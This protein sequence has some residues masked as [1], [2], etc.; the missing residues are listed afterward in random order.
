M[1]SRSDF[2]FFRL[3]QNIVRARKIISD[4][5]I[6]AVPEDSKGNPPGRGIPIHFPTDSSRVFQIKMQQR[7]P[8]NTT[9]ETMTEARPLIPGLF[10]LAAGAGEPVPQNTFTLG[11]TPFAEMMLNPKKLEA[12]LKAIARLE[13]PVMRRL[14]GGRLTKPPRARRA[15]VL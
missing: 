10:Q 2:L 15:R 11:Q 4:R 6:P 14:S 13:K 1:E 3:H 5:V 7:M 12:I 9:F 8:M